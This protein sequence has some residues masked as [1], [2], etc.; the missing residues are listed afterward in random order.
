MN[1][2]LEKNSPREK[3]ILVLSAL[4]GGFMLLLDVLTKLWVVKCFK[5]YESVTVIPGLFNFTSV[6]NY[7]AAWSILSGYGWLLLVFALSVAV[8]LAIFFRKLAEGWSERYFALMLLLSGIIGNS[9]DRFFRGAVVDFLHVHWKEVWHYPV[10][11]VADIAICCG[12]GL[13]ILSNLLRK[14]P[15][16]AGGK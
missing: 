16:S 7:G 12:V 11:N 2:I 15:E 5:L 6:R 13:Y 10:F 1:G 8:V 14:K 3:K 9:F 4:V